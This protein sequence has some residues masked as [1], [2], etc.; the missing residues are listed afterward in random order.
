[1]VNSLSLFR[2]SVPNFTPAFCHLLLMV[3]LGTL[4]P[5]SC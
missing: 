5:T 3:L 2:S 4:V 1:M